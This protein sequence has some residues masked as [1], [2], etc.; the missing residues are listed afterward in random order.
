MALNG[1]VRVKTVFN[2][3]LTKRRDG[4][5]EYFAWNTNMPLSY[6]TANVPQEF[7]RKLQGPDLKETGRKTEKREGVSVIN[8]TKCVLLK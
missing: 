6:I 3:P 7:F 2:V 1:K 8:H 5:F 4:F